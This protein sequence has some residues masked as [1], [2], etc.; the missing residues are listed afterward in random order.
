METLEEGYLAHNVEVTDRLESGKVFECGVD[1]IC[2]SSGFIGSPYSK[3]KI[4]H[5]CPPPQIKLR[6]EGKLKRSSGIGA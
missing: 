1:E 6:G 5:V 4:L 3:R 2:N